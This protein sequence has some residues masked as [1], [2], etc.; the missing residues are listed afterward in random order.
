MTAQDRLLWT[1]T[2][3]AGQTWH[4]VPGYGSVPWP[5]GV[6]TEHARYIGDLHRPGR[7]LDRPV[8]ILRWLGLVVGVHGTCKLCGTR[9][10]CREALWARAW[11]RAGEP[12]S[13]PEERPCE[14]GARG[15][16]PDDLEHGSALG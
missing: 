10:P 1:Y 8:P 12:I 7:T 4:T 15:P 5:I 11:L 3:A 14:P 9:W 6:I 13:P 2:D 16:I